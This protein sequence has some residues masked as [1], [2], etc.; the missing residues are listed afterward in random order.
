M[1][2]LLKHPETPQAPHKM[3][4]ET[5]RYPEVLEEVPHE[6]PCDT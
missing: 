6:K 1:R 2:Y 3:P 4:F 5:A